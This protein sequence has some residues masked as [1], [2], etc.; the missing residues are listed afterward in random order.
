MPRPRSSLTS[1]FSSRKPA[2]LVAHDRRLVRLL[3]QNWQE[4]TDQDRI[5]ASR[6]FQ[7]PV[8]QWTTLQSEWCEA[9]VKHLGLKVPVREKRQSQLSSPKEEISAVRWSLPLAPPG[10]PQRFRKVEP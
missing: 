4:L 5:T 3:E 1:P 2:K 9:T 8:E 10:K 6:I 7:R